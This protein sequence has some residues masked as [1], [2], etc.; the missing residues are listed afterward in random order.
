MEEGGKEVG[1]RE[2]GGRGVVLQWREVSR[3]CSLCLWEASDYGTTALRLRGSEA[4]TL[5][6]YWM[7]QRLAG[8]NR[9]LTGE[10]LFWNSNSS[11][12]FLSLS[13]PTAFYKIMKMKKKKKQMCSVNHKSSRAGRA[14]VICNRQ[15]ERVSR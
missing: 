3:D 11:L 1:G 9:H 5:H 7:G 10:F 4:L 12:F 14:S 15:S 8:G 2:A 13:S 6:Y